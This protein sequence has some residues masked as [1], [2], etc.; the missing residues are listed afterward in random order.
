MPPRSGPAPSACTRAAERVDADYASE[1]ATVADGPAK[2]R[3]CKIGERSQRPTRDPRDRRLERPAAAVRPGTESRRL[4]PTPP[5]LAAPV[6][7]TWGQVTPF[8][9]DSGNQFRPRRRPR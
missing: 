8:V 4:P 3:A 5:N 6:F 7:T 9:L 1:L 2:E